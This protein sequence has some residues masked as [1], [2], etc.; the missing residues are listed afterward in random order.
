MA[1]EH[2]RSLLVYGIKMGT[3]FLRFRN[4]LLSHMGIACLEFLGL[5]IFRRILETQ[6]KDCHSTS[7]LLLLKC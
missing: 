5:W 2:L 6:S 3:R 7:K 1:L 4:G